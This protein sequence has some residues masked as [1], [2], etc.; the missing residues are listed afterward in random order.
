MSVFSFFGSHLK[1]YKFK[2]KNRLFVLIVS[3]FFLV[4]FSHITK[5]LHE[6]FIESG[7][8]YVTGDMVIRHSN[9]DIFFDFTD[10]LINILDTENLCGSLETTFNE[11]ESLCPIVKTMAIVFIKDQYYDMMLYGVDDRISN[12]L[13]I[14]LDKPLTI[15]Y[16]DILLPDY[17]SYWHED[18]STNTKIDII[19]KYRDRINSFS[20]Q[21]ISFIGFFDLYT[22]HVA[23]MNRET[24]NDLFYQS[25]DISH[26]IIL[27]LKDNSELASIKFEN[28]LNAYFKNRKMALSAYSWIQAGE[29]YRDIAIIIQYVSL[30]LKICLLSIVFIVLYNNFLFD[31]NDRTKEFALSLAL[32][33]S[34]RNIWIMNIFQILL[35]I[36]IVCV[37]CFILFL[38]LYLFIFSKTFPFFSL[39]SFF[40][41]PPLEYS[42]EI[43]AFFRNSLYLLIISLIPLIMNMRKIINRNLK[44]L[45]NV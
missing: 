29:Q 11:I 15:D 45:M 35:E 13:S 17:F 31:L 8:N 28:K 44:D 25:N 26:E 10:T 43:V 42:F 6:Y 38:F 37:L 30:L 24:I 39:L 20:A 41:D 21:L 36:V 40:S 18:L 3:L 23:Y 2:G 33:N 4:F 5:S 12:V 32:G 19:L 34:K 22:S 7:Q 27:R 9:S 16:N 14:S 1:R